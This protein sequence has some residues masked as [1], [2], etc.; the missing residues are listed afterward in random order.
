MSNKKV[1]DVVVLDEKEKKVKKNKKNKKVEKAVVEEVVS[2]EV[3][4]V[5]VLDTSDVVEESSTT[6]AQNSEQVIK[7]EIKIEKKRR[8]WDE[9]KSFFILVIIIALVIL[10]GYLFVKYAEPIE[11]NK[12]K[13][14]NKEEIIINNNDDYEVLSYVTEVKDGHL[15]FINNKYLVEYSGK[16]ITKIM[17]KDLNILYESDEEEKYIVSEGVNGNLYAYTT[18]EADDGLILNLYV[19]ENEKLVEVKEFSNVGIYYTPLYTDNYLVGIVGNNCYLDDELNSVCDTEL[20]TLDEKSNELENLYVEGDL[21]QGTGKDAPIFTRNSKYVVV[22]D[23]A[24]SKYGLYDLVNHEI[25]IKPAYDDL[26]TTYNNSYVALKDGKVGI[27]DKK[28]KKLVDFDYD[29]IDINK[30]YYIVSKEN[31]LAIL[32]NEYKLLTGFE[33]PY[34]NYTDNVVNGG[35][36][37]RDSLVN[38]NSFA[39]LKLNDKYLLINNIKNQV[40]YTYL[41]DSVYFIEGKDLYINYDVESFGVEDLLYSYSIDTGMLV[42]YDDMMI[43]KLTID[44]S[45]YDFE[46]YP[47]IELVNSNTVVVTMDSELYFDY[48]TG[49]EIENIQ[50]VSYSEGDLV[51]DYTQKNGKVVVLSGDNEIVSYSYDPLVHKKPYNKIEE[52]SFYYISDTSFVLIMKR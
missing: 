33:F 48:E 21:K 38:I 40:G 1:T 50:D 17:D 44:L 4:S 3:S 6:E 41:A 29:F 35:Y 10:G 51:F 30:D 7:D 15:N 32:D 39:S 42:I 47:K 49:E 19:L 34:Y 24:D 26:Y 11:W 12:K 31:K 2:E 52:D 22:K 46:K 5:E 20:F 8:F 16:Y 27:I 45:D 37:S 36:I 13:N 14:E 9:V 43:E 25:I 28:L 18:G 23:I